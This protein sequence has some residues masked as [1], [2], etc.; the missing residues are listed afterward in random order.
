M[1]KLGIVSREEFLRPSASL[2]GR[3]IHALSRSRVSLHL[4]DLPPEPSAEDIALFER[5]MPYVR[6]SSGVY[7]TTARGRFS[8]LD[9]LANQILQTNFPSSG[10]LRVEDWAASDCFTSYEW[11]QLLLPLYPN[12]SFKASDLLLYLVEAH[13][14]GSAERFVFEPDGTA[15]QHVIPPFVIRMGQPE[16]WTTPLNRILYNRAVKRWHRLRPS[17]EVPEAWNN[18]LERGEAERDEWTLRRLPLIH[19][20]SLRLALQDTRFAVQQHSVFAA[21]PSPTDVIRTMNIFNRAYFSEHQLQLGIRKVIESLVP[22]GIWIM[23]RTV[24]EKPSVHEVTFFRRQEDGSLRALQ[25]IGPGSEIED[26]ALKA[27]QLERAI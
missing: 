9:P 23:G 19:P 1:L 5:L 10:V 25:R 6:L 13:R 15:L 7:R 17:L 11:A 21:S 20:E 2:T 22:G 24:K 27:S 3:V 18:P 8:D 14:K 16:K 4:L 26:L 12:L